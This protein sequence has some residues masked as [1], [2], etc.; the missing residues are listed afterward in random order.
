MFGLIARWTVSDQHREQVLAAL[1]RMTAE[2]EKHEPG[3]LL[4]QS[5][6]L[7]DNQNVILLYERYVDAEAFAVHGE[8][9]HF[10]S[11]VLGEIVPLLDHRERINLIP[12]H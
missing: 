12:V 8:T 7:E 3:C 1:A 4:Y 2:V 5:N 9:D 6:L 11:I 10:K